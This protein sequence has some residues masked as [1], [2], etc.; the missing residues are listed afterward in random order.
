MPGHM[1]ATGVTT[2]NLKVMK[3]DVQN[4]IILVKGAVPG[5]KNNYIIIK[6]A[7]KKTAKVQKVAAVGV[8]G[9]K[10]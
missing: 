3:I 10:K 9:A 6:K 4:N 2:Q 8:K 1:G 5:Y 7:K